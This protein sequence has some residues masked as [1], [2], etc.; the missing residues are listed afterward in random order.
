LYWL[1]RHFLWFRTDYGVLALAVLSV[2][3]WLAIRFWYRRMCEVSEGRPRPACNVSIPPSVP[4]HGV[5][6]KRSFLCLAAVPVFWALYVVVLSVVGQCRSRPWGLLEYVCCFC[7]FGGAGAW[8]LTLAGTFFG[9][10]ALRSAPHKGWAAVAFALN[11]LIYLLSLGLVILGLPILNLLL[12]S[13]HMAGFLISDFLLALVGLSVSGWVA[14]R[15]LYRR[16]R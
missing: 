10:T 3:G 16:Q 6:I 1:Q 7:F 11:L 8:L 15:F 4:E 13:W 12:P 2:A 9:W 14:M 5:M